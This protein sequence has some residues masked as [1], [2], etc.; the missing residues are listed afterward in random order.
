VGRSIR[1]IS[2]NRGEISVPLADFGPSTPC[3]SLFCQKSPKRHAV[4]QRVAGS[5]NVSYKK[6]VRQSSAESVS[7]SGTIA[8]RNC[9][10]RAK[11]KEKKEIFVT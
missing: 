7:F 4:A 8:V 1:K 9:K 10:Q 11:R 2:R 6:S 3:R 5:D